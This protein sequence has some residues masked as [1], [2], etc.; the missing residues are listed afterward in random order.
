MISLHSSGNL[1]Y[2]DYGSSGNLHQQETALARL[3]SA[4]TGYPAVS[5]QKDSADAAGCSDYLVR[6]RGI[7]AATIENGAGPAPVGREEFPALQTACRELLL[8]LAHF[9]ADRI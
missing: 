9:Y 7:P 8:A 2:W 5:V 3:L 6:V 1:I 4:A